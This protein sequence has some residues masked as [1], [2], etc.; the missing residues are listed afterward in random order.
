VARTPLQEP[1]AVQLVALVAVH[2]S[3]AVPPATMLAGLTSSVTVGGGPVT[4]TLAD[5]LPL[6]PAPEQESVYVAVPVLA[7]V[8]LTAPLVALR[9]LQ[10]PLAVHV[11]ALS[12][13]QVMVALLPSG[14][15]AG[16]AVMV[17]TGGGVLTVTVVDA[18]V[19]GPPP[20]QV[21]TYLTLPVFV[22]ICAL[23]PL[24]ATVPLQPPLAVHEVAPL[25]DQVNSVEAPRTIAWGAALKVTVGV[26]AWALPALVSKIAAPQRWRVRIDVFARARFTA[27]PVLTCPLLRM[28]ISVTISITM[29][30]S[31]DLYGGLRDG[32]AGWPIRAGW[33][34]GV[35]GPPLSVD[36]N[37]A[38]L[39]DLASRKPTP[40]TG[41]ADMVSTG[42]PSCT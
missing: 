26:A 16:L 30:W 15:D 22:G 41:L 19:D 7:G 34:E 1:L 38:T 14:I 21:S 3:V 37:R 24:V 32:S 17:T 5:V 8:T 12:T 31:Q 4:V 10:A 2:D 42:D 35:S 27:S 13:D 6:P 33:R 36:R 25:D 20:L 11:F 39:S 23:L 18:L 9:P 29:T 28:R 40:P